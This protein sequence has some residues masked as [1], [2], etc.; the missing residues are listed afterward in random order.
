[1]VIPV[2]AVTIVV[3]AI[4]AVVPVVVVVVVIIVPGV[5]PPVIGRVVAVRRVVVIRVTPAGVP[6]G[7]IVVRVVRVI[8]IAVGDTEE[9][10]PPAVAEAEAP[11][12]S[13][14]VII[15]VVVV[16]G[17]DVAGGGGVIVI[18]NDRFL[19]VGRL[20]DV[21]AV[22]W[23]GLRVFATLVVRPGGER[24]G[25][26]GSGPDLPGDG[27]PGRLFVPGPVV[28]VEVLFGKFLIDS[29]F[30]SGGGF[31]DHDGIRLAL[32]DDG[33]TLD[34][35][36]D[37]NLGRLFLGDLD[38]LGGGRDGDVAR[39]RVG[40]VVATAGYQ[41]ERGDEED[42]GGGQWDG[43]ANLLPCFYIRV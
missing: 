30:R 7:A 41:D 34:R 43:G 36:L 15:V 40:I 16:V 25:R 3:A 38:H 20:I 28:E 39:F 33:S 32:D 42:Q 35:F 22:G 1:V 31:L 24:N 12:A 10:A 6:V 29:G 37:D 27:S 14:V 18:L 4:V 11:G 2:V 8:G 5:V 9:A 19:G 17:G 13:R 23:G 21:D 26:D